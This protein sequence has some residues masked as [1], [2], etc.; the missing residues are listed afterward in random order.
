M[1][2]TIIYTLHRFYGTI[3]PNVRKPLGKN[4]R[5]KFQKIPFLESKNNP[6]I[7][8]YIQCDSKLIGIR[9]IDNKFCNTIIKETKSPIV[10]TSVNIHGNPPMK[11]IKQIAKKFNHIAVF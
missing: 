1:E 2:N 5:I 4:I 9:V 6:K 10:T 7:S 8:P 11:D 3:Y